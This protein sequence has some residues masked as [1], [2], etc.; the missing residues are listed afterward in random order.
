MIITV[1]NRLVDEVKTKVTSLEILRSMEA[2]QKT[3]LSRKTRCD[4]NFSQR[5]GL[6]NWEMFRFKFEIQ[7][8]TYA[9]LS[10][11]IFTFYLDDWLW[12]WIVMPTARTLAPATFDGWSSVIAEVVKIPAPR[13]LGKVVSDRSTSYTSTV[14]GASTTWIWVKTPSSRSEA[15]QMGWEQESWLMQ[16][17]DGLKENQDLFIG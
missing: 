12:R 3:P 16:F 15:C 17:S 8:S 1:W 13:K 9:I 10:L 6:R 11:A 2:L 14:L 5:L 4:T 7:P